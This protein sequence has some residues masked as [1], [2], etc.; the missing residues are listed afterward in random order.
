M[1]IRMVILI[2][3]NFM[4]FIKRLQLD[5]SRYRLKRI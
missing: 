2:R 5:G 1:L 3:I 4:I